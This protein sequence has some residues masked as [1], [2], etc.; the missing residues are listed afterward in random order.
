MYFHWLVLGVL[1]RTPWRLFARQMREERAECFHKNRKEIVLA[2][3]S[4]FKQDVSGSLRRWS[5]GLSRRT[6][7][8]VT[9][10]VQ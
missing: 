5:S 1:I 2:R 7:N 9:R 4:F 3:S 8:R 10:G 6:A